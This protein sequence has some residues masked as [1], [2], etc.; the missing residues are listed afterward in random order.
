MHIT[1][2]HIEQVA[3]AI[4]EVLE[5]CGIPGAGLAQYAL[6]GVKGLRQSAEAKAQLAALLQ[7]AEAEFIREAAERGLGDVAGWVRDMPQHNRPAFQQALQSLL[8]NWDEGALQQLLEQEF[9]G[10]EPPA[11]RQKPPPCT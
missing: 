6:R 7:E 2:E 1:P 9:A 10:R 8:E 3:D 11:G 4:L 5:A